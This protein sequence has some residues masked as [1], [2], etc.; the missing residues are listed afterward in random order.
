MVDPGG[1]S[2]SYEHGTLVACVV[3]RRRMEDTWESIKG[4]NN[5]FKEMCSGFE[6]GSYLRLIHVVY[7]STLGLRVIKQLEEVPKRVSFTVKQ[8]TFC[9]SL[10]SCRG[11]A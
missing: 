1:G 6:V 11:T 2:V 4:K 8:A 5:Y 3:S 10:L 9:T 7:H